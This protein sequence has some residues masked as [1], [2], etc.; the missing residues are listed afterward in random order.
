[1]FADSGTRETSNL[2]NEGKRGHSINTQNMKWQGRI[3][4]E[5]FINHKKL[6]YTT[7]YKEVQGPEWNG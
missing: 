7:Q 3:T 6:I 1:M 2:I 5:S 4:T